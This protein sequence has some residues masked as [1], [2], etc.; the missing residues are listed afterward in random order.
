MDRPLLEKRV[1]NIFARANLDRNSE[2]EIDRLGKEV[3]G[4][5]PE[6]LPVL[7]SYIHHPNGNHRAL[8]CAVLTVLDKRDLRE[9]LKET[10]FQILEDPNCPKE[11][12][13]N[14]LS[15]LACIQ[16]YEIDYDRLLRS[17]IKPEMLQEKMRNI[18]E[19]MLKVNRGGGP[20]SEERINFTMEKGWKF[21]RGGLGDG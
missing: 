15:V 16:G 9:K 7:L 12:K 8:A 14:A 11:E 18:L 4:L 6:V 5:G 10:L 1:R 17:V 20:L 2:E 21:Y 3:E 13:H 19:G